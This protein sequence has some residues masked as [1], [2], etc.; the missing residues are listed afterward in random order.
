MLPISTQPSEIELVTKYRVCCE[1]N[2]GQAM[3][4]ERLR[5]PAIKWLPECEK[6]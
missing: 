6:Q 2:D 4:S 1:K 5:N 3:Q